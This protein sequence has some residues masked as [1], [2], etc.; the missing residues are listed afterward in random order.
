MNIFLLALLEVIIVILFLSITIQCSIALSNCKKFRKTVKANTDET[1]P[2]P[3]NK[4]TQA[5]N[6]LGWTVGIG[7]TTVGISIL[8]GIAIAVF[9]MVIGAEV[10]GVAAGAEGLAEMGE[11]AEEGESAEGLIEAEKEGVKGA[12]EAVESSKDVQSMFKKYGTDLYKS[13]KNSAIERRDKMINEDL[14]KLGEE[15]KGGFF[16][17]RDFFNFDG[18][19]NTFKSVFFISS[20]IVLLGLG[21][22]ATTAAYDIGQADKIYT[23]DGFTYDKH[24]GHSEATTAAEIGLVPTGIMVVWASLNW[25]YLSK[26][27]KKETKDN[28]EIVKND[29]EILAT[30]DEMEKERKDLARS[31]YQEKLEQENQLK[32]A[33][34]QGKVEIQKARAQYGIPPSQPP[35]DKKKAS[36]ATVVYSQPPPLPPRNPQAPLP[37][38]NPPKA[39]ASIASQ[40]NSILDTANTVLNHPLVKEGFNQAFGGAAPAKK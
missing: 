12:K 21:I 17:F 16:Y 10:E 13:A 36:R 22:L 5:Q 3:L 33:A 34:I 9:E 24:T 18:D 29:K 23:K 7:W 28:K 26:I 27:K 20:I 2:V 8:V 35:V 1:N 37:P 19:E 15:A 38:G 6:L 4:L 31:V 30:A 11:I 32:M 39:S 25:I 14:N 40:A